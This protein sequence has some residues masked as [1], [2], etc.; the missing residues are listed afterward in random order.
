MEIF[1]HVLIK[2]LQLQILA[3]SMEWV[4]LPDAS[5]SESHEEFNLVN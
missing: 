3:T 1:P 5:P 4:N 2:V